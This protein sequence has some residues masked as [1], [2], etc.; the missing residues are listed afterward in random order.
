MIMAFVG[1]TDRILFV[2]ASVTH[3]VDNYTAQ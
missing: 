3:N 2:F 1:P